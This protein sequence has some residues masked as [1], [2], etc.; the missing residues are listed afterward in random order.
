MNSAQLLL[1]RDFSLP[2]GY[3]YI[4]TKP[5]DLVWSLS[6]YEDMNIPLRKNDLDIL[7]GASA[8]IPA[9]STSSENGEK[10]L[11]VVIEMTLPTSSYATMALREVMKQ[12]TSA[13]FHTSLMAPKE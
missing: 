3:R 7:N 1:F 11:A 9:A 10:N 5:K 13:E 4:V 2:G 12:G 6:E 8:E